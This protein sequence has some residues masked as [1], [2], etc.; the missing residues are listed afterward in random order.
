M[1]F[2]STMTLAANVDDSLITIWDQGVILTYTPELVA[3][4]LA[5]IKK[6]EQAK[7]IDFTIYSNLALPSAL[8]E[9]TDPTS[10]ALV[11]TL[12]YITPAEEGLVVT[13]G[14]LASFQTGGK[15][16][17]AAAQLVGRN[18][19]ATQDKRAITALEAFTTEII[20]PNTAVS[21]ATCADTDV[22]DYRFASRLYNKLA[23]KNV[24]GING[25]YFAIAHDD[26]LFDLRAD[27]VPVRQY[28]D[29]SGV[30]MN[31][32]GMAAGIRWLRS[33]NVTV[34]SNS[35]GTIDTYKVCV[36]GANALGKAVSNEPHP[37]ITSTDK[38]SRFVN[39]GWY[40]CFAYG[41]IDVTAMTQGICASSVG[42]N[43]A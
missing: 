19:G 43:A 9:D 8:T 3:D 26:C 28:A 5:T 32:I 18:M 1:P 10:V 33:S 4:Q 7:Q 17:T 22:L 20:Y 12:A 16:D 38:L 29:L 40:G 25:S 15:V 39:I 14:A 41:V 21:A 23:R 6:N 30:M 35:N 31:E 27:L 11:D 37:V 42:A 13:R 34:T 2:T 36:V 24:M